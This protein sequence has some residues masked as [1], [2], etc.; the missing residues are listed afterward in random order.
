LKDNAARFSYL[1]KMEYSLLAIPASFASAERE[2]SAA[3]RHSLGSKNRTTQDALGYKV[4]L[5]C[6]KDILLP[7]FFLASS[8]LIFIYQE[9]RQS[10]SVPLLFLLTSNGKSYRRTLHSV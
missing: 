8:L 9:V 1:T 10:T 6:N 7:M 3:G 5:T 2:F 4:F